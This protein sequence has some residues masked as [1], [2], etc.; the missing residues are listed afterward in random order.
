VAV[1]QPCSSLTASCETPNCS[2]IEVKEA[3]ASSNEETASRLALAHCGRLRRYPATQQSYLV[4][5]PLYAVRASCAF[6]IRCLATKSPD[7]RGSELFLETLLG[8]PG[9][10][11]EMK[12]FPTLRPRLSRPGQLWIAREVNVLGIA[13]RLVSPGQ[14]STSREVRV[15][16]SV[17]RLERLGQ[18]QAH[19]QVNVLGSAGRLLTPGQFSTN[20]SVSEFGRAGRFV[21]PGQLSTRRYFNEFKS[22]GRL[23]R[24][25]QLSRVSAASELGRAGRLVRPGHLSMRKL[26]NVLGSAGMLVRPGQCLISRKCKVL[27]SSGRLVR[28]GQSIS[29]SIF[30]SGFSET[31]AVS[32]SLDS[33]RMAMIPFRNA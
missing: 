19:R 11:S 25:G 1:Q 7:P 23:V 15:L 33:K 5:L 32:F 6:C 22:A 26:I 8:L 24:A 27:G 29:S 16:G 3:L 12:S 17:G 13:G 28:P 10:M 2:H 14:F 9:Y 21:R 31:Y 30:S 20:S 4:A 18:L